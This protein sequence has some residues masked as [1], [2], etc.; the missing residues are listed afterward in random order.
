M[1]AYFIS[2][3]LIFTFFFSPALSNTPNRCDY[4][5]AHP[6]DPEA[7][8]AGAPD[9]SIDLGV[10]IPACEQALNA[11]PDNPRLQ[12]QLGR[13]Y[14]EADRDDEAIELFR[15]AALGGDYSAAYAFLGIAYEYGYATGA[16][17][18]ELARSLYHVALQR[19][20]NPAQDL[21]A[22]L[23]PARA[24]SPLPG[25]NS[26]DFS[27]YYQPQILQNIYEEKFDELNEEPLKVVF[28]L[29]GMYEFFQQKVNW[30]DLKCAHLHDTR[31]MQK[32]VRNLMGA[33]PQ[34]AVSGASGI[35][36]RVLSQVQG[37]LQSGDIAGLVTGYMEMQILPDEG[38]RDAGHLVSDNNDNCEAETIKRLYKNAQYYFLREMKLR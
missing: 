33:N 15:R 9:G 17:E 10:A 24:I 32:V 3:F 8:A 20:F 5:A 7:I 11:D 18:T 30:F 38:N 19:G 28:Y 16:P 26:V 35:V 12:F 14:W 31:L 6:D 37:K 34:T 2:I 22:A 21:L 4:V 27:G 23:A 36:E 29:R 13:A 25:T 1:R